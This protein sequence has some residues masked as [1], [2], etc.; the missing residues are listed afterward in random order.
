MHTKYQKLFLNKKLLKETL[1]QK[2]KYSKSNQ[3]KNA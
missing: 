3:K 1:H 2:K